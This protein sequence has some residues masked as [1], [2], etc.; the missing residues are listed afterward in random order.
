MSKTDIRDSCD[1]I[2]DIYYV[3]TQKS[4]YVDNNYLHR[5]SESHTAQTT[6]RFARNAALSNIMLY[7]IGIIYVM[8]DRT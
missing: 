1:I 4:K 2:T 3:Y 6:V 8:I 5:N 7:A